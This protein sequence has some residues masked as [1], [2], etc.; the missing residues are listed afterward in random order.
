MNRQA[1]SFRAYELLAR[2][3]PGIE[4][5]LVDMDTNELGAYFRDVCVLLWYQG[6]ELINPQLRKG[7]GGS[8]GDDA[9]NL[10]PSVISWIVALFENPNPPLSPTTKM[11]R[12]FEHDITGRLLCPMDYNWDDME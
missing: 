4:K 1:R 8:R 12:G 3:V 9:A 7:S 5:K 10:K 6:G 2:H 11:D